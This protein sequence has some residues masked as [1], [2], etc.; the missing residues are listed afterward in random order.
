MFWGALLGIGLAWS[1]PDIMAIL[2][3]VFAMKI[4]DDDV[5][6]V[7]RIPSELQLKDVA[8]VTGVALLM[9]LLATLYP[10]WRAT[11]VQPAR[12]LHSNH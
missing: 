11:R 5:Y 2:E 7:S 9:S 12:A 1:L 3:S 10:A 4:L 6:F 8:L